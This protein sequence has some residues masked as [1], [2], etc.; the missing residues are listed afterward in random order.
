MICI[1]ESSVLSVSPRILYNYGWKPQ[2]VMGPSDSTAP[3]LAS[4]IVALVLGHL[5]G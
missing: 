3:S 1:N 2:R 4:A 5:H